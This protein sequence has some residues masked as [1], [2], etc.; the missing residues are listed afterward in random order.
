MLFW[1][2][3]ISLVAIV[4]WTG[5]KSYRSYPSFSYALDDSM[6]V[7]LI[8]PMLSL[9][10][11]A[12]ID[13]TSEPNIVKESGYAEILSVENQNSL[14][15]SFV[16]G[17]GSISNRNVYVFYKKTS[18]GGLLKDYVNA[19]S[20]PVYEDNTV[21]PRIVEFTH[22][23]DYPKIFPWK[24]ESSKTYKIYVPEGTVIKEFSL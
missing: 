19:Y 17:T 3:C 18:D 14:T 13:L 8:G 21:S 2:L 11:F 6:F 4:G 24:Y 20:T 5:Y 1:I 15:G 7:L 10:L 16:L 22:Y 23:K 9:P 12:I